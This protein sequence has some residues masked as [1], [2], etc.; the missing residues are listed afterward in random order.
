[1]KNLFGTL[2]VNINIIFEQS[3]TLLGLSLKG[4]SKGTA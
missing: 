4:F 3:G 1:M 2:P